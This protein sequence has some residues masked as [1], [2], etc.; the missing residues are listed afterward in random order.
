MGGA[1]FTSHACASRAFR[2]GRADILCARVRGAC[3][4]PVHQLPPIRP[5]FPGT[6]THAAAHMQQPVEVQVSAPD[7]AIP[8]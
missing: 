4:P 8:S 2:G 7:D 5:R 3:A 1:R 6:V